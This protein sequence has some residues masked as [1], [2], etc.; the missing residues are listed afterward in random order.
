MFSP[1]HLHCMNSSCSR[2][3]IRVLILSIHLP[4]HRRPTIVMQQVLPFLQHA[5]LGSQ[6]PQ[7]TLP[8]ARRCSTR[9]F[10][11]LFL[12]YRK[13]YP[14]HLR[15]VLLRDMRRNPVRVAASLALTDLRVFGQRRLWAQIPFIE[16]QLIYYSTLPS[17]FEYYYFLYLLTYMS[18]H[19]S[20][21]H[22]FLSLLLTLACD[23]YIRG[24]C[25]P[26][27]LF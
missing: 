14:H 18:R 25:R 2:Y 26:F 20:S 11:T 15:G 3:P 27:H 1:P 21:E 19:H 6:Q 5:V 23:S 22:C 8:L 4:A 13:P 24:S 9:M 17:C 7:A 16:N 12:L 10:S